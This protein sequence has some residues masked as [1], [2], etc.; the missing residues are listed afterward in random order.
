MKKKILS[1]AVLIALG[2]FSFTN[3][4]ETVLQALRQNP[5]DGPE[6]PTVGIDWKGGSGTIERTFMHQP[7]VIPHDIKGFTISATQNDCLSCHGVPDSGMPKPHPSHYR[8]REGNTTESISQRWYF[9]TQCHV[10]QVEAEPL[11]E[12]I[13]PGS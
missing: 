9:C 5:I 12:N 7:P 11:V 2:S 13:F 6:D 1:L 4:E 8:D 3:A 10:G